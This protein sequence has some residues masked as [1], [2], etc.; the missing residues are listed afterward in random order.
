MDPHVFIT[1]RG[2]APPLLAPLVPACAQV[3]DF[4]EILMEEPDLVIA[5]VTLFFDLDRAHR[6]GT[7]TP[8][9]PSAQPSAAPQSPGRA[10]AAAAAGGVEEGKDGEAAAADSLEAPTPRGGPLWKRGSNK[11]MSGA[12]A[13]RVGKAVA[14]SRL[15]LEGLFDLGVPLA[16]ADALAVFH[17]FLAGAGHLQSDLGRCARR[18]R[19]WGGPSPA[20]P[21]GPV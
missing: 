4:R 7:P 20:P 11:K 9:A 17:G 16:E 21:F 3:E 12:F 14:E 8:R 10:A 2:V 6:G 5:L 18:G 13:A 19:R 1:R 15:L